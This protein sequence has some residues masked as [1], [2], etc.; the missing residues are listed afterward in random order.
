YPAH[1]PDVADQQ[2]DLMCGR[3]NNIHTTTVAVTSSFDSTTI[4]QH[5]LKD[6][7]IQRRDKNVPT[8]M[9]KRL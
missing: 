2:L 8:L 6:I 5:Q 9:V 1:K 7:N 3:V 4:Q